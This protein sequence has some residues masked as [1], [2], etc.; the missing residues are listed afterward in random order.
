MRLLRTIVA[1][2]VAISLAALP[3]GAS[4]VALPT[5]K[6]G[7]PSETHIHAGP[8]HAS[9]DHASKMAIDE[10]C[11]HANGSVPVSKHDTKCPLGSCCVGVTVAVAPAVSAQF[12]VLVF[13]EGRFPV[14]TDRF[15]PDHAGSP[16]FRPPRV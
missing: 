11:H 5:I 12:K 6:F 9:M 1:L 14:R 4:A 15:V 7:S 13:K 16:P 10:P 8:T 3:L 2:L